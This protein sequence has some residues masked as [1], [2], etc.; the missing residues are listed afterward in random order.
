MRLISSLFLAG[1]VLCTILSCRKPNNNINYE[2][3]YGESVLYLKNSGANIVYPKTSRTDGSYTSFPKG[4]EIDAATGAIDLSK[5]ETGLRYRITFK[6]NNGE[7]YNTTIV[8]SGVNYEDK[9]Y[10]L[11][12]DSIAYPAYNATSSLTVPGSFDYDHTARDMGLEIDP[13]TGAIDLRKT[14]HSNLINYKNGIR[15]E[16]EIRYKLKDQSNEAPN[17]IKILVYYY[18]S[19]Q[20][21]DKEVNLATTVK[22]HIDMLNLVQTK[23]ADKPRPPCVIIVDN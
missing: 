21:A 9:Y 19:Q 6:A 4:L 3:S 2:L 1:C 7:I 13:F 10:S 8:V 14:S 15:Q 5:S 17:S 11:R 20:E 16:V 18:K 23:S 22:E 12:I